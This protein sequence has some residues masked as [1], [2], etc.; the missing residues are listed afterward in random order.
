MTTYNTGSPVPSG[1]ARDRFDNTQ[2]LDEVVNGPLE[3]YKNRTGQNVLSLRGMR[4]QFDAGQQQRD[5]AFQEFLEGSGWQDLGAYA[6]GISITS[7]SQTVDYEGQPY[8][9]KP[10]VPASIDAPYITTGNW[11]T[12]GVN[13]KLVGDN[14]LRQ[15]L[16]SSDGADA[17]GYG[18]ESVKDALD[19]M[20]LNLIFSDEARFGGV[21][22]NAFAA[23]QNGTRLIIR[24]N[25]TTN[26]PLSVQ[27]KKNILIEF[28]PSSTLTGTNPWSQDY[29]RGVMSF[30]Q[31]ENVAVGRPQ[32]KGACAQLATNLEDGDAGIEFIECIN[33]E[34]LK[35]YLTN[36]MTWGVVHVG[37][38]NTLVDGVRI[39]KLTQQS[40]VANAD[41]KGFTV[42]NCNID[43]SGLYG[44]ECEGIN[45]SN[46]TVYGNRVA[47]CLKGV[48]LVRGNTNT[49]VW[50]NQIESCDVGLSSN[51]A[52]GDSVANSLTN[53]D[54]LNCRVD[55]EMAGSLRLTSKLNTS[56]RT[57][58]SEYLH[59]STL[60]YIVELV[61][62]TQ[63]KVRTP[64]SSLSVGQ[65][66]NYFGTL[67][68]VTAIS[69]S[70]SGVFGTVSLVTYAS[71]IGLTFGA[72]FRVLSQLSDSSFFSQIVGNNSNLDFSENTVDSCA[73]AYYFQGPLSNSYIKN[74]V[75]NATILLDSADAVPAGNTRFVVTDGDLNSIPNIA[76]GDT[77]TTIFPSIMG[78][79][80][81]LVA[82][83]NSAVGFSTSP[84]S[85]V[86]KCVLSIFT[87]GSASADVV[88][89]MNST[90]VLTIPA[91]EFGT[92][93]P[94]VKTIPLNA[95]AS[96]FFFD[97]TGGGALTFASATFEVTTIP[98]S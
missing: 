39:S 27:G 98:I 77:P 67:Y 95:K 69:P 45:N 63:V 89:S 94:V 15:D 75:S 84:A 30:G 58:P 53:N 48:A 10:S 36:F 22:A 57:V 32:V 54:L 60:D 16:A 79:S 74:R 41:S 29:F 2:T 18:A 9:L 25:Y 82:G 4:M 38:T 80:R 17:V 68:T 3:F 24:G 76:F 61:G 42:R 56:Q 26:Q 51:S 55:H 43:D 34:V 97:I 23:I 37:C 20:N 13:F 1:D 46:G 59:R 62:S 35:G 81:T 65:V 85:N 12:E 14:S 93:N 33:T 66:H 50:G 6:A 78:K 83:K 31:C 28:A 90:A 96:T 70:T 44:I 19:R 72:A 52:F 86:T 7:H 11:A 5:E 21:L 71:N 73:R 8:Q 92:G 40:G 91:A 47:R 49:K 88:V 64:I 87:S